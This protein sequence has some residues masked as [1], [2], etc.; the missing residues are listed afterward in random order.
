MS[1]FV[2][3]VLVA[4]NV[5]T[6]QGHS[7]VAC[8]DYRGDVNYFEQDKCLAWPRN[9]RP[10]PLPNGYQ[11]ALPDSRAF[12]NGGCD[13]EMSLPDWK[14]DYSA[15]FPYAVYEPGKVYCLAW[16]MKNHGWLPESC[17]NQQSKS[18]A[19]INDSLE[20]YV[21]TVNPLKDPTQEEFFTRN[22][23]EL[24]G[25]A[26]NCNPQNVGSNELKDECQLGLEKQENWKA[27]CK[28]FHRA[29]KF[30]NSSGESMG[31]GC[32]KVP[33]DMKPGHYV[34]QWYWES[35]FIRGTP[36]EPVFQRLSYMSCFDFT[37]VS[38][39]S[40]E[41]RPG[42][43]GT[44]G[45]PDTSLP[46][47]NNRLMFDADL[48]IAP[49]STTSTSTPTPVTTSSAM[50]GAG[51][52][53]SGEVCAKP[54]WVP[55]ACCEPSQTCQFYR[56]TGYARCLLAATTATTTTTATTMTTTTT[57]MGPAT[58][59]R[60]AEQICAEPG[61]GPLCCPSGYKCTFHQDSGYARCLRVEETACVAP[62]G[63]CAGPS[64]GPTCCTAEYECSYYQN[65]GY[66]R[67]LPAIS[68]FRKQPQLHWQQ[69]LDTPRSRKF[70]QAES[71]VSVHRPKLQSSKSK[72]LGLIQTK[73][74]MNLTSTR[75][76][77]TSSEL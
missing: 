67:C 42:S 6:L 11:I 15:E 77:E 3:L 64:W 9:Y 54:G 20:L 48:G 55:Q 43:P 21:S 62:H 7:W 33:L 56:D 37:V 76:L 51:C 16:P 36:E 57:T 69:L 1:M 70:N 29:P 68:A 19:G 49:G 75:L 46:C 8:T 22:I 34:A 17:E 73:S 30:C 12:Q 71:G 39:G 4:H 2:L 45:Q 38:A 47:K 26:S 35:S 60:G 66:A 59:C 41:A 52:I 27:D 63:A 61:W 74:R 25:L 10:A 23:N 24:A 58:G 14:N 5:E 32:F 31:T 13:V 40:S 72:F 50:P 18:D 65:S 44:T 53:K 28:G